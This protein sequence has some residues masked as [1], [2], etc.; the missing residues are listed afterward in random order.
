[1]LAQPISHT[2]DDRGRIWVA[3]NF[4]YPH[5]SLEGHDRIVI[6]DDPGRT[7][8]FTTRTVFYDKL[9]YVTGLE[10]GFGGVYVIS[11]PNLLFIPIKADGSAG[12]PEVLLEGFGHQ[13]VHNIVNG[14][15]WGPDGWLWGGHGGTSSGIIGAPGAREKTPFDGG[16][17]R[18]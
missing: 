3:E 9:N 8:H 12:A 1:D 14:C 7:G 4:S 6:L 18:Y 10:L 15:V 16:V 17:W 2:T 11:A 5:W 13:G